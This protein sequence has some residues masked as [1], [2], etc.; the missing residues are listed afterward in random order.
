MKL[1]RLMTVLLQLSASSLVLAG[2][3]SVEIPDF[4]AHITLPASGDGY[5][6]KTVSTDEGRIPKEQWDITRRRGIVILSEDWKILRFSLMKN[7]LT[8]KCKQAVGAFD[9]LFYTLDGT[10][11]KL[12]ISSPVRK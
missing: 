9:D 2:C 1:K 8:M 5:W 10:L 3:A 12:P 11:K 7:C 4:K 6:V